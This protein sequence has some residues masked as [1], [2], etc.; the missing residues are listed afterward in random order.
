MKKLKSILFILGCNALLLGA[1]WGSTIEGYSSFGTF[2]FV[3]IW[4][5]LVLNIGLMFLPD[6]QK[7][8]KKTYKESLW[9]EKALSIIIGFVMI[10]TLILTG[11]PITA[12]VLTVTQL[13]R[14]EIV[15]GD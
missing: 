14:Y 2:A 12:V 13:F 10:L 4:I 1:L 15:S 5:V 9:I 7:E 6:F 3:F 8:I 11:S